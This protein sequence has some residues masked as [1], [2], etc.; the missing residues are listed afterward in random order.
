LKFVALPV[1]EI[2]G[3]AQKISAVPGYAHADFSQIVKGLLFGW[4]A[5]VQVPKLNFVALR[6]PE[7]IGG[8]QKIWA[9][10]AYA[11]A[12]FSPT[13]LRGFSSGGPCE[14]TGQI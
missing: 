9:V 6:V 10:P 14:Y 1:P 2:I 12:P 7:I 13:F 4:T 11:H 3:G 5:Y 8:T